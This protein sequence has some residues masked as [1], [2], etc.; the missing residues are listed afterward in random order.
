M[1][2]RRLDVMFAVGSLLLL[3]V[4]AFT[5]VGFSAAEHHTNVDQ[6]VSTATANDAS[7]SV[8]SEVVLY[9][10]GPDAIS[11]RMETAIVTAF[12]QRGT[13]VR[14]VSHLDPVYDDPVLLVGIQKSRIAYNPITP[15]AEVALS[16]VY[17]PS[18]NVTQ[19]R[20]PNDA[21]TSFNASLLR[22][23]LVDDDPIVF[24]VDDENRIFRKG[25]VRLT[26]STTGVVS[27]PAY[28]AYVVETF[29]ERSVDAVLSGTA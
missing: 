9:V 15:S 26:D 6:Q 4:G 24:R 10:F 7:V 16:F 1:I 8:P 25:G 21:N 18:G 17:A 2:S 3:L 5:F 20:Q 28:R 22:E 11:N 19:F 23:R 29:A 13:S 14:I 12:E 27:W